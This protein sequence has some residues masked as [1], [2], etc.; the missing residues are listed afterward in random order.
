MGGNAGGKLLKTLWRKV[1]AGL[2]GIGTN[3]VNGQKLDPGGLKE[4]L[5]GSEK[6]H[7]KP[8]FPDGLV[9]ITR[10]Y[11][12]WIGKEGERRRDGKYFHKEPGAAG[13]QARRKPF[14]KI[15]LELVINIKA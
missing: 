2:A 11:H 5:F 15:S 3:T 6:R 4:A 14:P 7:K 9:W 8:F 13:D 10:F 12:F 1:S